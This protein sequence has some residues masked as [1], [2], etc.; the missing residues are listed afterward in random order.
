MTKILN[1]WPYHLLH[2]YQT[3]TVHS[4]TQDL[5]VKI[6]EISIY[7]T[8]EEYFSHTLIGQ[9]GGDQPSTV[10]LRAAK[11]KQNGFCH[12]FF[13]NKVTLWAASYS[14]SVVYTK[15]IIH[16]GVGVSGGYLPPL[17]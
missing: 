2:T 6:L 7:H 9:L 4:Y 16:L 14:A 15:T 13:T 8:S 5:H 1:F 12:Y 3:Y 10:H 17:W 11:E